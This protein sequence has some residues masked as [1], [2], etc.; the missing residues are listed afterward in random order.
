[1]T[2]RDTAIKAIR[3]ALRRRSGKTWSVKGGRGTA[4][5]WITIS[6][7][8]KRLGCA[9]FCRLVDGA[10][11]ADCG[12]HHTEPNARPDGVCAKHQ[13]SADCWTAYIVPEDRREL[14]ALLGLARVHA[15]GESVPASSDYRAEYVARAEGRAPTVI[16]EQYWD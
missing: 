16:G 8:P 6:A 7:P 9:R 5:G 15:Q 3:T 10:S 14:A 4:Y 11:C 2:D 13:C 12:R 1:M